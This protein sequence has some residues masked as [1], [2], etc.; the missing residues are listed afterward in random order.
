MEFLAKKNLTDYSGIRLLV[1]DLDGTLIDSKDDLVH[2]VNAVRHRLGL[3]PLPEETVASYVGRGVV[4]LMRRALGEGASE[5]EVAQAVEFFLEYYRDHMLDHTVAYP[6]VREALEDLKPRSMAVLTN[7]PVKFSQAI[8]AGLGLSPYFMQV[9]G[10]NSFAQ[11]KPDPVGILALMRDTGV[12]AEHTMMVGDSDTD[13]LT[14]RNAGVWTCGVTY[15][16]APETLKTSPPDFLLGDMRELPKLLGNHH[17]SAPPAT[18][19][20]TKSGS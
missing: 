6:G 18:A 9:Y 7:K 2:S 15:G 17:V 13:V 10:G 8:L 20:K 14:G 19:E 4:V 11:K 16:L 12:E 1:F 3:Q 5:A